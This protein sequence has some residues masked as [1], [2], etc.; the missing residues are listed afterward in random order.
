[1][2]S[3]EV[4]VAKRRGFCR[5]VEIAVDILEMVLELYDPPIFMKHQI[6]HNT[7]VVEQFQRKGV[8]FVENVEEIPQGV[9]AVFSAHGSPPEDYEIAEARGIEVIDA[10]CPLVVKVHLEAIK[11]AKMSY[12]IIVVGHKG[13]IEP[14]GVL[15]RIPEAQRRFVETVAEAKAVEIPDPNKVIRLTQTTLA[16][17]DVE[18]VTT[19][20][21]E[22]FPN[23]LAPK[24]L[25]YATDERQAAVQQLARRA[26]LVLVV[27]SQESS[28][29]QRLR[30]VA[31]Q[32]GAKEARLVDKASNIDVNWLKGVRRVVVT[33]GASVP[34][35]LVQEV[36]DY[37]RE[38]GA[39]RIEERAVREEYVPPFKIP[40]EV[41]HKAE[42]KGKDPVQIRRTIAQ[43]W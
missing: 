31:T 43:K 5:G 2:P 32:Y 13:H 16:A 21:K 18:E 3:F 40:K 19:A 26:D 25:C 30:E 17:N 34:D 24:D 7:F 23:L 29:S 36:L 38:Q 12:T 8:I 10:V 33:S 22:R 28:N 11:Y 1:M 4:L 9:V 41:A 39:V 35:I 6:V 20:L 27:G 42:E 37:L 14:K 15:G